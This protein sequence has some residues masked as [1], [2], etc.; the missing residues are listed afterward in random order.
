ME[1]ALQSIMKFVILEKTLKKV[2][3]SQN[4]C[5]TH[6]LEVDLTKILGDHET[7]SKVHHVRLHVDFSSMKDPLGL[8][9]FTFVCEVNL[10]GLC[11][12]D[13]WELLDYNGHGP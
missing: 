7:L 3:V 12:F 13:Q 11:P 5:Q 8:W 2:M 6:L 10:D 4:L 1:C 9:A